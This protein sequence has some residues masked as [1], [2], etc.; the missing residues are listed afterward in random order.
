MIR[1]R[2]Y[3]LFGFAVLLFHST[4]NAQFKYVG[5]SLAGDYTFNKNSTIGFPNY[6]IND[7]QFTPENSLNLDINVLTRYYLYHNIFTGIEFGYNKCKL[8]YIGDEKTKVIKGNQAV[9]AIIRHNISAEFDWLYPSIFIG[10]RHKF[11]SVGI[12]NRFNINLSGQYSRSQTIVQ[13]DSMY[14]INPA[15]Q[16]I[17]TIDSISSIVY[18]PFFRLTYN[19]GK[20]LFPSSPFSLEI[21]AEYSF[22][23]NSFLD[24]FSITTSS[25]K[26]GINIGL[27]FANRTNE[28]ITIN[29]TIY[30]RDTSVIYSY[31][32]S[33]PTVTI[34]ST[35]TKKNTSNKNGIIHNITT[36]T[37]HYSRKLPRP[38]SLLNGEL[39]T[40]FIAENGIEMKECVISYSEIMIIRNYPYI[41]NHK[42][43]FE[44]DSQMIESIE[45][46]TIRFYTSFIAEAG[47]DSMI[48]KLYSNGNLIK[49]I[50]NTDE[51]TN[52]IEVNIDSLI[53]L[54]TTQSLDYELNL[55]DMEGQRK[56]AASGRVMMKIRKSNKLYIKQLFYVDLNIDN[57]YISEIIKNAKSISSNYQIIAYYNDEINREQKDRIEII[58][59]NEPTIKYISLC[60]QEFLSRFTYKNQDIERH[61]ILIIEK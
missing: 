44:K 17:T 35:I 47:L 10:Y 46:P 50:V 3:L 12:G 30:K 58:A 9:D 21:D 15:P 59:E 25:I 4:L 33:S 43:E 26:F 40:V 55:I 22:A 1:F 52:F 49:E 18:M 45:I 16:S 19:I 8:P 54:K 36:V 48:I 14:F 20:E 38:H 31:N 2:I 37:Q 56:K 7:I 60:K 5:V 27:D 13:P 28:Q 41:R 34:L 29:D 6:P 42:V 23:L 11:F 51:K 57:N 39:S 32:V 24:Q 53:D 61:L